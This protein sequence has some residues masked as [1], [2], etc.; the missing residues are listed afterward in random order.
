MRGLGFQ[1]ARRG[2]SLG[3]PLAL[4][5]VAQAFVGGPAPLS[6]SIS[7]IQ[8]FGVFLWLLVFL[9]SLFGWGSLI[10]RR[11][12][13]ESTPVEALLFGGFFLSFCGM[14]AGISGCL[15]DERRWL[16]WALLLFGF[17]GVE[18]GGTVQKIRALF[19]RRFALFSFLL[20]FLV[21]ALFFHGAMIPNQFQDVLSYHLYA[22][23]R[24]WQEGRI[25]FDPHYPHLFWASSWEYLYFWAFALVGSSGARLIGALVFSQGLH[26]ALGYGGSCLVIYGILRELGA[27][28]AWRWLGALM[29]C[30]VYPLLWTVW[31]AKND[32]GAL[33]WCLGSAYLLVR[34]RA[35][36]S[37][38]SA[39]MAMAA[40]F[41]VVF[42]VFF[43]PL[44]S[45]FLE[46][47]KK[48]KLRRAWLVPAGL[49]LALFP[50]LLRNFLFAGN[51][52]YP[53]FSSVF[54]GAAV[55]DSMQRFSYSTLGAPSLAENARLLAPLLAGFFFRDPFAL[56]GLAFLAWSAWRGDRKSSFFFSLVAFSLLLPLWWLG[57]HADEILYLRYLAPAICLLNG[58][59]VAFFSRLAEGKKTAYGLFGLLLLFFFFSRAYIPW[60]EIAPARARPDFYAQFLAIDG[61]RCKAWM[62]EHW[63]NESVLS[64]ED[65]SLYFLPLRN[66][67]VAFHDPGID[68]L[69]LREKSGPAL[70]SLLRDQGIRYVYDTLHA[71]GNHY[72][73]NSSALTAWLRGQER[74]QVF[75]AKDCVV[76][77]LWKLPRP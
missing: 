65:D 1:A 72:Y 14:A 28:P 64:L 58:F 50:F 55:S 39:G 63:R 42:F 24:W 66:M 17:P 8:C 9:S 36:S 6:Q 5:F 22:P 4:S 76:V 61:G 35:L 32:F 10:S 70:F 29:A 57:R 37:G 23:W 67:R 74:A 16:F 41:S 33:F 30:T 54:G 43:L 3:L 47:E 60:A 13:G 7:A 48:E 49:S 45:F 11:L 75:S 19:L 77:D 51:P 31:L 40:K 20:F 12:Y 21:S 15:G 26:A 53:L 44:S 34:G 38:W 73:L 62:A 71:A 52:L 2:L 18:W 27:R 68:A 46:G 25:F 69:V 59:A 56:L